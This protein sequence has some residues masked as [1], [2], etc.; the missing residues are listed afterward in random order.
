LQPAEIPVLLFCGAVNAGSADV[1]LFDATLALAVVTF[2]VAIVPIAL[3][4][5]EQHRARRASRSQIAAILKILQE[6]LRLLEAEPLRAPDVLA[7]GLNGFLERSLEPDVPRALSGSELSL[8]YDALGAASAAI[9]TALDQDRILRS[10]NAAQAA[11]VA[12]LA[13]DTIVKRASEALRAI[14][15]IQPKLV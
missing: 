10:V 12:Q 2:F 4:Q 5:I 8:V 6:R 9:N 13:K 3:D 11:A 14:E 1:G 15:I 7:A